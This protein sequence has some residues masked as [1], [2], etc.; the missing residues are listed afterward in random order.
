MQYSDGLTDET[1][2]GSIERLIGRGAVLNPQE[3][4]LQLALAQMAS[5]LDTIRANQLRQA[6]QL[7]DLRRRLRSEK[8]KRSR[9]GTPMASRD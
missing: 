5:L 6:K 9:G 1:V 8:R 3:Y 4:N 2:S 7:D